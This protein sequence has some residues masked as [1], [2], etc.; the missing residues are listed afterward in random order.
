MSRRLEAIAKVWLRLAAML[1]RDGNFAAPRLIVLEYGGCR[2]CKL[3]S[4][5]RETDSVVPALLLDVARWRTV[6]PTTNGWM[7]LVR[8]RATEMCIPLY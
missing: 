7:C 3:L 4:I 6:S 2:P 1:K 5:S 8:G